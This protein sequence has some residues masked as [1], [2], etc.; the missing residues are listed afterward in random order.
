M[1]EAELWGGQELHPYE[2]SCLGLFPCSSF[3]EL[4]NLG[5]FLAQIPHEQLG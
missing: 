1:E 3:K 4:A 5:P 2:A